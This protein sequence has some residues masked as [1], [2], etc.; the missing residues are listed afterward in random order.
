VPDGR[1]DRDNGIRGAT[2]EDEASRA[3]GHLERTARGDKEL[4]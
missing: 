4:I 3:V 2:E 1:G